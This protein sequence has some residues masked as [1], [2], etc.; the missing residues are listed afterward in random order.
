MTRG[1]D[2]DMNYLLKFPI[3]VWV[4]SGEVF[5]NPSGKMQGIEWTVGWRWNHLEI[6][7]RQNQRVIQREQR[8]TVEHDL[9][10]EKHILRLMKGSLASNRSHSDGEMIV[11]SSW[12]GRRMFSQA[13]G[14]LVGQQNS[15]QPVVKQG[16]WSQKTDSELY[17]QD[18][19]ETLRVR[20]PRSVRLLIERFL[21]LDR[22]PWMNC[23]WASN[24]K[25]PDLS[26]LRKPIDW[27]NTPSRFVN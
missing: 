21:R 19:V 15:E 12:L 16:H 8:T 6:D 14:E 1:V 25:W 13:S 10:T 7:Q 2:I 4:S 17:K 27:H 18:D 22:L 26:R 23:V 20:I 3:E 9:E 24:Q 5:V 11:L